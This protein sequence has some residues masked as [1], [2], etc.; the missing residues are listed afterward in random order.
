MHVYSVVFCLF[1]YIAKSCWLLWFECSVHVSDG[2]PKQKVL[3]GWVGVLS[4]IQVYFGFLDFWTLQ[5]PLEVRSMVEGRE[6]LVSDV[7]QPLPLV[8]Q[9]EQ[10]CKQKE[11][12]WLCDISLVI[13]MSDYVLSLKH[14]NDASHWQCG[15]EQKQ[16]T[17]TALIYR[18]RPN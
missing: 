14:L 16:A 2:F 12:K 9:P 3:M 10:R 15:T 6:K 18:I 7:N 13:H 17:L 11:I 5:S 4:S 1:L 8:Q